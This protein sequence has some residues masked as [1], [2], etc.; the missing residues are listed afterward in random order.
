MNKIGSV[1]VNGDTWIHRYQTYVTLERM[2]KTL[3]T[4]QCIIFITLLPM[5][6]PTI[7]NTLGSSQCPI[8]FSDFN[9]IW[10]FLTDFHKSHE[11][12]IPQ[13]SVQQDPLWYVQTEGHDEA[14]RCFSELCTYN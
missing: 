2:M 13:K 5:S 1:H 12:Q 4:Q 7:W 14:S 10:I 6:L 3:P 9:Q 8:F 11:Y